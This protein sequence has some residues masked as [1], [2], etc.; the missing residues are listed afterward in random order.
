MLA[1]PVLNLADLCCRQRANSG[2]MRVWEWQVPEPSN[3][4]NFRKSPAKPPPAVNLPTVVWAVI[5]LII[6]IHAFLELAGPKWQTFAEYEFAFI[7]ARFG[8]AAFPQHE[9]SAWW[10][11]LTY[12]LL[13]ANWMH[14]LL[15]SLWLAVFSKPVQAH[16]GTPRYLLI[17]GVGIISGAVASLLVH[18][19]EAIDLVGIS[20][21]V[22]ALLA[23]AIPLMYGKGRPLRPI[24]LITNRSALI[25]TLVWLAMTVFTGA[26][27]YLSNT[28]VAEN[29]IAWD[30]HLGGFI[31]GL[32]MF[33]ILEAVAQPAS[34]PTLH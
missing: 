21:G 5:A 30:A 2:M 11:M 14:V 34:R 29:Q 4:I 25:F 23:A 31:A 15:N 12:G 17:L 13:H 18:W 19:G 9:G 1:C 6:G 27:A 8:P 3:V 26:S 28:F 22:S 33:Y 32:I 20:A 24:E 10:S 16:F 7:P